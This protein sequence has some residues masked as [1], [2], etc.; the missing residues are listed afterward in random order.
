M[1]NYK[2]VAVIHHLGSLNRGHYYANVK[3][4]NDWYEFDDDKVTRAGIYG[5]RNTSKSAYLLFYQRV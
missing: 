1:V 3:T 2:L 5:M 4:N